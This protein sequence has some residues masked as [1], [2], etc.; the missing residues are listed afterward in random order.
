MYKA[1][2]NETRLRIVLSEGV[3]TINNSEH[4]GRHPIEAAATGFSLQRTP[5]AVARHHH[6]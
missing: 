6:V 2:S 4:R 5:Q 1:C 3:E